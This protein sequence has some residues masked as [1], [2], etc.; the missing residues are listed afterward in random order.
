MRGLSSSSFPGFGE[1]VWFDVLFYDIKDLGVIFLGRYS[2][3]GGDDGTSR[4]RN[5]VGPKFIKKRVL[6]SLYW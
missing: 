1:G 3:D 4:S 5:A 6:V 2:G